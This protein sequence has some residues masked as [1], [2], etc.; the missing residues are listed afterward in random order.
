MKTPAERT[1][2]AYA[3]ALERHLEELHGPPFVLSPRDWA[4]ADEWHHRGV[5]LAAVIECLTDASERRPRGRSSRRSPPRLANVQRQ[6]NETWSVLQAGRLNPIP[7]ALSS[8]YED[9]VRGIWKRAS[10]RAGAESALGSLIDSVLTRL[11]AGEDPESLDRVLDLEIL[12]VVSAESLAQV[13]NFV[14]AE[15]AAFQGRWPENQ[16]RDAR[17]AGLRSRLRRQLGLPRLSGRP[18]Q[19]A[20]SLREKE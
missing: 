14:E 20:I 11:A 12:G 17:D 16:F 1:A 15:L 3:R 10:E 5:P 2:A 18:A 7:V 9:E 13:R 6:V 8:A 4:L 19:R